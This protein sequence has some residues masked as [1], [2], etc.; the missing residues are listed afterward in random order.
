MIFNGVRNQTIEFKII[1]YEIPENQGPSYEANFLY[2]ELDIKSDFGNWQTD[3]CALSTTDVEKIIDW[4]Y[5]LARNEPA[6]SQVSFV[7]KGISFNL[8]EETDVKKHISIQFHS[9]CIPQ[10]RDDIKS[11]SIDLEMNSI[12]LTSLYEGLQKELDLY[13]SRGFAE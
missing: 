3:G 12:E 13:P 9:Y 6:I 8:L 1:D 2:I 11:Y 10:N 5:K 4:F 7:E